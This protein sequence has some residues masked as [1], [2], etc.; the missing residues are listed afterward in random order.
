MQE[1]INAGLQERLAMAEAGLQQARNLAEGRAGE[2]GVLAQQ[3][4]E[5]RAQLAEATSKW[6]EGEVLRRRLHNTIMVQQRPGG[7]LQQGS[8]EW[9]YHGNVSMRNSPCCGS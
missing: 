1:E 4:C 8:V 6:Q 3:A 5:L 2:A 7:M 9:G